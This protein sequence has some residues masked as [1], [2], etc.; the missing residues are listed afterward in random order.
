MSEPYELEPK[1]VAPSLP[2]E[3]GVF[4]SLEE[5][6]DA[7]A[8]DLFA[9]ALGC[10]RTFGDFHLA[11]SGGSLVERLCLRLMVDP[12]FRS[13]PWTRTQLWVVGDGPDSGA[14]DPRASHIIHE[15]LRDHAGIPRSQ[16][17]TLEHDAA[18]GRSAYERSVLEGLE[19][20][21]K[22]HDRLD[23][24][25]VGLDHPTPIAGLKPAEQL[26]D[27]AAVGSFRASDGAAHTAMTPWLLSAS[28]FLA[29]IVGGAD[30][31][32]VIDTFST[33]SESNGDATALPVKLIA[34]MQRWYVEQPG[35]AGANM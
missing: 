35:P 24:V 3:V 13:L 19:W 12:K 25:V 18:D 28:R 31:G 6:L 33:R 32:R 10:V 21:E 11:I 7:V 5:L 15:I 16:I 8:S 1:P 2:G 30:A 26:A 17:H 22:G 9:Q 23:F 14:C 29:L 4:A 20:R 27:G 34:G